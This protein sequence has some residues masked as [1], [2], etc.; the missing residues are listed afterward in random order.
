M[1]PISNT[2]IARII[3]DFSNLSASWPAVAD[4]STNGRMNTA[5]ATL[6]SVLASSVVMLAA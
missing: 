1:M 3:R 6:T 4:S 5:A 2:L